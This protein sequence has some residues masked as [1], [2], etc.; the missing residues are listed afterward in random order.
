MVLA[1]VSMKV[2]D[3]QLKVLQYFAAPKDRPDQLA[4]GDLNK[5]VDKYDF[6][7]ENVIELLKQL[8]LKFEDD[9]L[10]GTKAET[11]ALNAYSLSKE[12]RDNAN[13]AAK[14][15][16]KEKTKE[17]ANTKKAIVD[18]N[19]VLKA[20]RSDLKD[21]SKSLADTED[22]CRIK[23]SE[24]EERSKTRSLEIEAMDQAMA[25]LSKATGVRTAAPGN[26]VPPPSPVKFLQL[27][28]VRGASEDPKMK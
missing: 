13:G 4:S 27:L 8:K 9:K 25:I 26:P 18:A 12:A 1:L 14:K 3:Q 10:A 19:K 7:S 20:T 11:N 16:K 15:S 22:A 24:W 21:D 2:T 28:Q 17:L 5:H 6:K 23:T